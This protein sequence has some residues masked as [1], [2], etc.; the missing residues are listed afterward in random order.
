MPRQAAPTQMAAHHTKMRVVSIAGTPMHARAVMGARFRGGPLFN[1]D[2]LLKTSASQAQ[3]A[4]N[5]GRLSGLSQW[6]TLRR[7]VQA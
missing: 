4:N 1:S 3:K 5:G 7:M 6:H 2:H